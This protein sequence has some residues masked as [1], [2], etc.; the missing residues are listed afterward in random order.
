MWSP[1]NTQS[2]RLEGTRDRKESLEGTVYTWALSVAFHYSEENFQQVLGCGGCA[3]NMW[4]LI[5][6]NKHLWR[7]GGGGEKTP[8]GLHSRATC[9]DLHCASDSRGP[10][11]PDKHTTSAQTHSAGKLGEVSK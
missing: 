8:A 7:R 3:G 6:A 5:C 4:Q 2:R 9:T 10:G 1:V 11:K